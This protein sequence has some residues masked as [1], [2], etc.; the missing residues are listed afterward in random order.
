MST[1]KTKRKREVGNPCHT[2]IGPTIRGFFFKVFRGTLDFILTSY[3]IIKNLVDL[4]VSTSCV[5]C[6]AGTPFLS[7]LKIAPWQ[8]QSE[9]KALELMLHENELTNDSH[10]CECEATAHSLISVSASPGLSK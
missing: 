9:T 7:V 8:L 10:V 6:S 1:N 4:V 5:F 2:P 3:Y